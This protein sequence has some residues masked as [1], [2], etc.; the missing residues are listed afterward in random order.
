MDGNNPIYYR[1]LVSP[2]D[3]ISKLIAQ[4][5]QLVQVYEGAKQ[6]IVGSAQQTAQSLQ[7]VSGAV[8]E[9]RKAIAV[10]SES[11]QKLVE[12]YNNVNTVLDETRAAQIAYNEAKKEAARMDKLIVQANTS[13]EG[14]YKN[15]S[16]RYNILKME[17]KGMAATDKESAEAMRIKQE[18]AKALY[19]QMNALQTA[20]GKYTLQ[21]GNYEIAAKSLRSELMDLTMQLAQMR[22]AGQQG[23]EAYNELSKK[24]GILKDAFMDAQQEIKNMASDTATLNSVAKGASAISGGMMAL[25]SS[26][27]LVGSSSENASEMQRKLGAAVG[28]VSG[29]M[30]IQ[31]AVQKQSALMLG[32][33]NIQT[34]AATKAEQAHARATATNT[35]ATLTQTVATKAA[36]V[37]QAAF[38][39][40]AKANP[41][42]LL[43]AGLATVVGAL[44]L[45]ISG[46]NKAAR[47]QKELVD[48]MKAEQDYIDSLTEKYNQMSDQRI[49]AIQNQIALR[50]AQGASISEIN[51]LEDDAWRERVRR[52]ATEKVL[53]QEALDNLDA[54]R[55]KVEQLQFAIKQVQEWKAKGM[56]RVKIDTDFDGKVENW[57]IDKLLENLQGQLDAY[58]AKVKVA[59]DITMEGEQ[60]VADKKIKDA[61]AAKEGAERAKAMKKAEMDAIRSMQDTELALMREGYDKELQQL[62]NASQRQIEDLQLRMKQEKDLT[63]KAREA[64]GK[65]ITLL[66]EKQ[67][68]D[69]A[70]LNK[71]YALQELATRRATEDM[72]VDLMDEGF[73]KESEVL[74]N[75][76]TRKINDIYATIQEAKNLTPKQI[77]EMLR[78]VSLL[79]QKYAKEKE[80]LDAKYD[81]QRL[82]KEKETLSLRLEGAKENSQEV[83][84]LTI[85]R[86]EKE[87]EIE[88]AENKRLTEDKRQDEAD[89]NK[90]WDEKILKQSREMNLKRAKMLYEQQEELAYSE[91]DLASHN[92]R[93]KTKYALEEQAKRIQF[94]LAND[95]TLTEEQIQ[96]YKNTLDKIQ[97]EIKSLPYNSFW[98]VLGLNLDSKQQDALNDAL[99]AI[100]DSIGMIT[101]SWKE[102]AAAAVE[103]A[104]KQVEA[105]QK[106]LD[107]ELEARANGYANNVEQAQKD[108]DLA[109][110]TREKA[111]RE[112]EKAQKAQL[113]IDTVTQASSLITAT[114]NIWS[115]LG[116]IPVVGPALALAAI[117][118]M[119]L[120]FG[121]AKIKAFQVAGA[122]K[123]QYGEGTVELLEGGSHAS[124]NDIDLGVTKSGKRR[125]AEGGEFFA[126]IN[127][128]NSTRYRNV[129]PEVINAFNDGTFGDKYQRANAAMAGLAVGMLGTD[130]SGIER[131]VRKIREQGESSHY[132]DGGGNFIIKY[133]NLTRKIKS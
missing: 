87:R 41:Y 45:F 47:A 2:D 126:V 5:E 123:E 31:N 65:Q 122:A 48:M 108:L 11:T 88:L 6:K 120:S 102:A 93:Q 19:E 39:I 55:K 132:L 77:D 74:K 23:S 32:I 69:E 104:D 10:A 118:A 25:N 110:K 40:V 106:V 133:K 4:L 101:D 62:R 67:K 59:T 127:K 3:S 109:K 71:K 51:K 28:I 26:L 34:W 100:R 43:A 29:L 76:Y 94:I 24:A 58:G 95:K 7:G 78:Q 63:A 73:E 46:T 103:A 117:A 9:Q 131:D 30:L 107:A 99:G 57:K 82:N 27:V 13:V 84:D 44:A 8:E 21:V 50:K 70:E 15:L 128:R 72:L 36:T 35:A 22:L 49:K 56:L 80:K 97:K 17:L 83:I 53:N 37:A 64:M 130:V 124:G 16:A 115:A 38:N 54:N 121:A 81:V 52:W 98:E 12:K 111:L 89:I 61:E 75:S 113:A 42:V 85:E 79:E 20:T 33:R 66:Q 114:A 90:K 18:Q 1:D 60:L 112:E 116:G 14:S 125:R 92:E 105:T 68:K 86:M 119:W 96:M 129:I 91:F